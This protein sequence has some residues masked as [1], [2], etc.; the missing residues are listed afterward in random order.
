VADRIE[1]PLQ[2]GWDKEFKSRDGL[3][4]KDLWRRAGRL[5]NAARRQARH[6]TGNLRAS[7]H[8]DWITG[9]GGDLAVQV[10][11]NVSY[12]RIHH[13]GSRPHV[14]RA[15]NAKVLRFT[16]RRGEVVFARSVNHPGTRPNR[17]LTDNLHIAVE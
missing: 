3:V 13:D 17:Y 8:R 7:M 14:I 5:L 15:R 6:R 9:K 4:G 11:S 1:V 10:G 12:A 16:N 2:P